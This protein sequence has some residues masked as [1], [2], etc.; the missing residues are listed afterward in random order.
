LFAFEALD[1]VEKK[2][3]LESGM[4]DE[5]ESMVLSSVALAGYWYFLGP[6]S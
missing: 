3:L 2:V 4:L 1:E 6:F 5:A